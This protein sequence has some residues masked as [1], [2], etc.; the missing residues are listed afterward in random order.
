MSILRTRDV[1]EFQFRRTDQQAD[2]RRNEA[3]TQAC[4]ELAV[5]VA[6]LCAKAANSGLLHNNMCILK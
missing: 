6:Q 2:T 4:L 1:D 3:L 5:Y